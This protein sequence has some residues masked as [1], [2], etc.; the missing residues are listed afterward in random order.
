MIKLV[1]ALKENWLIWLF[2]KFSLY[3]T[4]Y[5]R[6]TAI[7]WSNWI[8]INNLDFWPAT[9][10]AQL[11]ESLFQGS[12]LSLI[13]ELILSQS[14]DWVLNPLTYLYNTELLPDLTIMI[15]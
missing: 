1:E 5:T 7:E 3:L 12:T 10:L 9:T 13:Q 11:F 15:V 2:I 6:D 8:F 14:P 4:I